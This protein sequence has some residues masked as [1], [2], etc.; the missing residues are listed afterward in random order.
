MTTMASQITSLMVV[1]SAVYSEADQRK[2]Q[3]SASLAFVQGIHRGPV[4]SLHKWPVARKMF[5]FDYVIMMWIKYVYL[6]TERPHLNTVIFF[7]Y[8]GTTLLTRDEKVCGVFCHFKV[9]VC[10]NFAIGQSQKSHKHMCHISR[11]TSQNGSLWNIE[12]VHYGIC[13]FSLLPQCILLNTVMKCVDY[14][15][16]LSLTHWGRDKIAVIS[17]TAFQMNFRRLKGSPKFVP[18][19]L[20]ETTSSLL[21]TMAWCRVS[22]PQ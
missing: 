17:Q 14:W 6:C 21:Q 2:H 1:Y 19:G 8:N 16:S 9:W 5:P 13:E 12:Q 20:I 7:K 22:R 11:C 10:F 15:S 18:K 4:N 3:S